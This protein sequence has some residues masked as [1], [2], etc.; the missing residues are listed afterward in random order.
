VAHDDPEIANLRKQFV[1]VRINRLNGIN[2]NRFEF[3]YDTTWNCFFLDKNLNVYS[4]YGGRDK[5]EPEQRMSKASLM[6]TMREVLSIHKKRKQGKNVPGQ[7]ALQPTPSKV[8]TPRDIPLLRQNHQG[9]VHCHQVKEYALLQAATDMQVNEQVLFPFPLPENLGIHFDINHGHRISKIVPDSPAASTK[10]KLG[11]VITAVGQVPVHSEY[12]F[13]WALHRIKQQKSIKISVDRPTKTKTPQQF[14]LNLQLPPKWRHTELGWRK[15]MRSIPLHLGCRGYSLLR[16]QRKKLGFTENQMAIKIISV[17]DS[18]LAANLKL[19]KGDFLVAL[20]SKSRNCTFEEF[21]SDLL[22]K[23][24]PGDTI[25]VTVIR[26]EKRINLSGTFPAWK[27]RDTY[28][29]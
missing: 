10:L 29:P 19:Q 11:D 6:Q 15:S 20:G 12:D 22:R 23:F 2:L 21:Q 8:R 27:A 18:G 28:V 16:T 24:Q 5:R 1:N 17:R 14:T 3:D 13:R 9:C 26:A 25:T 4:R 7:T